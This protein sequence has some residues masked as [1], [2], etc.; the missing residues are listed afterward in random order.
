MNSTPSRR[1]CRHCRKFFSPDYRNRHHQYYCSKPDCRRTSK[2]ASQCLWLRKPANRNHFHGPQEIQRVQEWRIAHPGYWKKKPLAPQETQPPVPQLTT[3]E[4]TSCNASGS[5]RGALQDFCLAKNPVFVGLLST[6]S[7]HTLQED[8]AATIGD[9]LF[10]GRKILGLG[11]PNQRHP[12][13]QPDNDWQTFPSTESSTANPQQLW[14]GRHRQT[15][16]DDDDFQ[17]LILPGFIHHD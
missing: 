5:A 16:R 15:G 4:K 3:P 10:R 12:K 11:H 9:L 6:L 13:P 1:K 17:Q 2:A 7:G 14:L 8:I